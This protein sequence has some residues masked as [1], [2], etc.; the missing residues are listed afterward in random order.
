MIEG[1][2]AAGLD[3]MLVIPYVEALAAIGD[4]A[5]GAQWLF[6]AIT[7]NQLHLERTDRFYSERDFHMRLA[8]DPRARVGSSVEQWNIWYPRVRA[9]LDRPPILPA[10]E[11]AFLA[12]TIR[13]LVRIRRTEAYLLLDD[14][15]RSGRILGVPAD[16]QDSAIALAL[17]CGNPEALRRKARYFLADVLTWSFGPWIVG[18]IAWLDGRTGADGELLAAVLDKVGWR[19]DDPRIGEEAAFRERA[20]RDRCAGGETPIERTAPR[21]SKP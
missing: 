13:D 3:E 9:V 11:S 7:A 20:I 1:A 18:E 17:I 14:V 8:L 2:F 5:S 12:R 15:E 4:T 6:L 19:R 21:Q 10:V 16:R